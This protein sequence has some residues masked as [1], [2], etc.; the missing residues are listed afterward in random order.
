MKGTAP[1]FWLK[2]GYAMGCSAGRVG[3]CRD[4][5]AV[6]EIAAEALRLG[7][8]CAGAEIYDF[9]IQNL[10]IT[11]NAVRFY[12]IEAGSYISLMKEE[13]KLNIDLLDSR[14]MRTAPETLFGDAAAAL[15]PGFSGFKIRLGSKIRDK[16]DFKSHYLREMINS[17]KSERLRINMCLSTKSKTLSGIIE[18]VL[19]ELYPKV[20]LGARDTYEFRG[21]ISDDGE[22]LTLLKSDGDPLNKEQTMSMIIYILLRDSSVR[23]FVLPDYVS[24]YT[25]DAILKLGGNVVRC[26]ADDNEFMDKILTY[27][28]SEQMLMQFDGL[29]AALKILDF[30]NRFD[31]SFDTLCDHLPRIFKAEAEVKCETG[32]TGSVLRA[33]KQQYGGAWQKNNKNALKIEAD[34]GV[35]IILPEKGGIIKIISESTSFEAAEEISAVFKN[36]VK[37]LANNQTL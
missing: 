34:G 5:E 35:A 20:E 7:A 1:L 36:N 19:K 4:D 18:T 2:L 26:G 31:L 12:K 10:P 23:T 37:T 13:N 6:S 11:R 17:V 25:E 16:S 28:S 8:E 3:V 29:Y 30:L 15:E 27:G 33:I 24:E 9:G 22:E 21:S 32:K 14:G